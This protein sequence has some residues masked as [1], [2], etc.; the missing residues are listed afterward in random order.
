MS[1][2]RL[3][4]VVIV[5]VPTL[6]RGH[7]RLAVKRRRQATDLLLKAFTRW[8]GGATALPSLGT[9]EMLDGSGIA[10][11][12]NQTVVFSM[13][14]RVVWRKQR[15][16][17]VRLASQVGDLLDQEAMAVVAFAKADGLLVFGAPKSPRS[18]R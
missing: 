12:R 3:D 9:W 11:D 2:V 15:A 7:R 5:P 16:R 13:T 18:K 17:V 1:L 10:I 4:Y 14:T 6:D 8:F